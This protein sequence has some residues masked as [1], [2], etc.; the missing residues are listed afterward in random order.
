MT[1]KIEYY[2]WMLS[3][4]EWCISWK[5][6]YKGVRIGGMHCGGFRSKQAAERVIE[7]LAQG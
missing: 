3:N 6:V 7:K 2:A 1:T 4:G 5:Q